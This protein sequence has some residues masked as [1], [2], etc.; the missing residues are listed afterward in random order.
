M[1]NRF[2]LSYIQKQYLNEQFL[3]ID[4]PHLNI[5]GYIFI[6]GRMDYAIFR[7][8]VRAVCEENNIL[9][10]FFVR[11]ENG[12][13]LQEVADI[14]T[15]VVV[16]DFSNEINPEKA[17][18]D[19]VANRMKTPFD[20]QSGK[21]FE[22]GI[23]LTDNNSYC[24][25]VYSHLIADGF[26]IAITAHK[27]A[28]YYD[29]IKR[30]AF[31]PSHNFSFFEF[32]DQ[33]KEYFNSAKY[34]SDSKFWKDK[35]K[36]LKE[37]NW[38]A[39]NI[40]RKNIVASAIAKEV[41]IDSEEYATILRYCSENNISIFNF[42][43]AV[44]M[45]II[46]ARTSRNKV[47]LNVRLQNRLSKPQKCSLGCFAS[48]APVMVEIGD[49][50]SS[51]F[52]S[53]S[54]DLKEGYRHQKCSWKEFYEGAISEGYDLGESI[55]F[56]YEP[57]DHNY[58]TG[59]FSS[60]VI[61]LFNGM[62]QCS[63][64]VR[65]REF[66]IQKKVVMSMYFDES[67]FSEEDMEIFVQKF[68]L[69]FNQ[70]ISESF[71][72]LKDI[73]I[74]TNIE[75]EIIRKM[76]D[77]EAI[78]YKDNLCSVLEDVANRKHINTAV[79]CNGRSY[80]YD[81]LFEI[82][83][84]V[85]GYLQSQ[86]VKVGDRVAVIMDYSVDMIACITG[87]FL[88]GAVFLPISKNDPLQ[89]IQKIIED[90]KSMLLVTDSL[91]D[92]VCKQVLFESITDSFQIFT[93]EHVED[94]S[95]CYMV[96]TSGSTGE[97]KGVINTHR[98]VVN[99]LEAWE[100][101]Y[102]IVGEEFVLLQTSSFAHDVF[103]GNYL[104]TVCTGGTL[105]LPTED[106][107]H[108]LSSLSRMIEDYNVNV[109]DSTPSLI[110]LLVGYMEKQNVD[111]STIKLVVVGSDICS[112]EDFRKLNAR[113]LN[114]AMVINSYGVSEAAIY[115]S[116]YFL[117]KDCKLPLYGNLPIGKPFRNTKMY[118]LDEDLRQVGVGVDGEL[119]IYGYGLAAGYTSSELTKQ[120]FIDIDDIGRVYRTGDLVRLLSDGNIQFIGRKD[121]QIKVRGY[122]VEPGEIESCIEKLFHVK[123]IV[124]T[125]DVYDSKVIVA[126]YQ[127][128]KEISHINFVLRLK[129]LLPD[130][131]V[132]NFFCRL[133]EMPIS[134]NGKVDRKILAEMKLI[135]PVSKLPEGDILSFDKSLVLSV[136]KEVLGAKFVASMSFIQMGADSLEAIKI[137][138]KLNGL[139]YK[140]SYLDI[141]R[142]FSLEDFY[143]TFIV[144]DKISD[145]DRANVVLLRCFGEGV[146]VKN[147]Y[148]EKL[149]KKIS[150]LY[151]SEDK[152]FLNKQGIID[153]CKQR[154]SNNIQ[155]QYLM[156]KDYKV[157][158]ANKAKELLVKVNKQEVE[159]FN[160]LISGGVSYKLE[161][162]LYSSDLRKFYRNVYF[163]SLIR[164]DDNKILEI[165]RAISEL[166][167]KNDLL[168]AGLV[169]NGLMKYSWEIFS[170]SDCCIPVLDL[171]SYEVFSS[172]DFVYSVLNEYFSSNN[173]LRR[174]TFRAIVVKFNLSETFLY[175][176]MD[177]SIHD[178]YGNMLINY[179]L[180]SVAN[181]GFKEYPKSIGYKE[182][183]H[184]FI[185]N[186]GL[187]NQEN[188]LS[189]LSLDEFIKHIN[190]YSK[191]LSK[192][193]CKQKKHSSFRY[194]IVINKSEINELNVAMNLFLVFAKSHFPFTN[195]PII[196]LHNTRFFDAESLANSIGAFIDGVPVIVDTTLSA[197]DNIVN[198]HSILEVVNQ[199]G[200]HFKNLLFN[201]N[202][203]S[204]PFSRRVKQIVGK[205]EETN[206]LLLFNFKQGDIS[207]DEVFSDDQS[208]INRWLYGISFNVTVVDGVCE[209]F[210]RFPYQVNA[211]EIRQAF[212]TKYTEIRDPQ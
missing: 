157:I 10:T 110:S 29:K 183:I 203:K 61:T 137:A 52:A 55:N 186:S 212:E 181:D 170:E 60:E 45:L 164:I 40:K 63:L 191:F 15:E 194:K 39:S 162:P 119:I 143:S 156:D 36:L 22:I 105:V 175:Y 182:Y 101:K 65:V 30:S 159:L 199:N 112:V 42:F 208:A 49:N 197:E 107:R 20:L 144:R 188:L 131:M 195:I 121:F 124:V 69:F 48:I 35:V 43:I 209:V 70:I 19:W 5:G 6:H 205:L 153:F 146:L 173:N 171:S 50:L 14:E 201:K 187:S 97:P 1:A 114:R 150:Y 33:D 122:R 149:S 16:R 189:E 93:K 75:Q 139:G 154:F 44:F 200:I 102:K 109:L 86:G 202:L 145:L 207:I 51:L 120:K 12:E 184:R 204:N 34:I 178:D 28:E 82:S 180:I 72:N 160:K 13:Y 163:V 8:A 56:S 132:P 53:I 108:S 130:Y 141:Y 135:I 211:N 38:S 54:N 85:S 79:I 140:C 91:L 127:S 142:S 59:G 126:Y 103:I 78:L 155:P 111:D 118:V 117:C 158:D 179:Y 71:S 24:Y 31:S 100:F 18:E 62:I 77:T 196:M 7:R 80:S 99:V 134:A 74:L 3:A 106:E 128:S 98:A 136:W 172:Y 87:I 193:I 177:D 25:S 2:P 123:A 26:S 96:Y 64:D 210:I 147:V 21:L 116:D 92:V 129:E 185:I 94:Y 57:H 46:R 133:D 4:S 165:S 11:N 169:K 9:K 95:P 152:S 115:S 89:R 206:R 174:F 81:Q 125:K 151:V 23:L 67:L 27:I 198:I 113:Y 161:D 47:L 176:F 76:N 17:C 58:L 68:R 32:L 166:M 66:Q 167:S 90:S 73:R 88:C 83:Y 41:E 104:K 192:K 84:R 138:S 168:R 190:I 37:Y 148:N